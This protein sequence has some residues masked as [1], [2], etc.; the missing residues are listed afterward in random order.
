MPL[1]ITHQEKTVLTL[2]A[3]LMILG[4]LGLVLL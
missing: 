4:L 1:R 3:I 2:I